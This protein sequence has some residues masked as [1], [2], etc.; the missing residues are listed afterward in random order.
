MGMKDWWKRLLARF[1]REEEVREDEQVVELVPA[2]APEPEPEQKTS[3]ELILQMAEAQAD[4]GR[5]EMQD[6]GSEE[7]Q[8]L[9]T[10]AEE[11]FEEGTDDE[12]FTE[13]A[14]EQAVF[15]EDFSKGEW[16]DFGD[17]LAYTGSIRC[18]TAETLQRR[19]SMR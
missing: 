3:D 16:D 9:R 5:S 12:L 17:S 10:A 19:R 11:D 2:P 14:I 13:E 6:A 8:G 4:A 7:P 15:D 1:S 18:L